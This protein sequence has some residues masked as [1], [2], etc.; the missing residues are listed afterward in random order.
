MCGVV[1][2]GRVLGWCIFLKGWCRETMKSFPYHP[3]KNT[4]DGIVLFVGNVGRDSH[5]P[6]LDCAYGELF[7]N[8]WRSTICNCGAIYVRGVIV[9]I[10]YVT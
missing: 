2:V 9:E 1:G 8:V 6:A 5:P 10:L 7:S 3:R 4:G